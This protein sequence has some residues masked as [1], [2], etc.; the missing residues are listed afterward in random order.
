M[1]KIQLN[2]RERPYHRMDPNFDPDAYQTRAVENNTYDSDPLFNEIF[3][4]QLGRDEIELIRFALERIGFHFEQERF[5]KGATYWG[6]VNSNITERIAELLG[7][8]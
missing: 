1:T 2:T 3:T 4:L 6:H 8:I 7:E 5:G